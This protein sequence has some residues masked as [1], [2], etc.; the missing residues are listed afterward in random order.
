L[1]IVQPFDHWSSSAARGCRTRGACCTSGGGVGVLQLHPRSE[2]S[3][4]TEQQLPPPETR[5]HNHWPGTTAPSPTQQQ[6]PSS[7][8]RCAGAE[9]FG[10][11][12]PRAGPPVGG[13]VRLLAR[14]AAVQDPA[15]AQK[16][17]LPLPARDAH[18]QPLLLIGAVCSS[19]RTCALPQYWA[20]ALAREACSCQHLAHTSCRSSA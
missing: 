19:I 3:H 4:A 9:C 5:L 17:L 14:L 2:P 16:A 13:P 11:R 8:Q 1:N 20:P 7:S 10:G 12:A 18:Q 15:L 6:P